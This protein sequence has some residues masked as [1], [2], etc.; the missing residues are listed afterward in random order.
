MSYK[1]ILV[2]CDASRSVGNRLSAA[3]DIAQRF[4]ARMIGVHVREPFDVVS[5]TG[6]GVP[7]H[8][9]DA[10]AKNFGMAVDSGHPMGPLELL[11]LIGLPVGIHVLTSLAVLGSRVESRDALLQHF[12]PG[13]QPPVT[14]WKTGK[15]NP[16]ALEAIRR[17][18]HSGAADRPHAAQRRASAPRR[19]RRLPL[20][21]P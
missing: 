3:A 10:V 13:N 14:F 1:T 19:H 9:I 6:E 4:E 12:L 17:Y 15:E 16:R 2:H 5:F 20:H 18:R 21:P 8:R 7:I 11:D